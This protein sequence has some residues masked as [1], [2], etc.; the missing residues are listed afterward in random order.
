ML[1]GKTIPVWLVGLMSAWMVAA[2]GEAQETSAREPVEEDWG[3]HRPVVS[4]DGRTIAFMSNRS[5][6]WSI[7]IMPLDGSTGPHRVSDDPR[8]EWYGDWSPDGSRLTYY[9]SDQDRSFLRSYIVATGEEHPMGPQ[10]GN[11]GGPRWTPDGE[12][13]LYTCR[14]LG[15]CAMTPEG[16]DRGVAYGLDGGQHDP[17]L[18]PDGEWIAFVD[19]LV[20]DAQD[21]FIVRVDGSARIRVTEDPGRTYGVDWSPD[22]RYLAYNTEVDGNADIYL[23]DLETGSSRR[24]TT[25]AAEEHLPRWAP[26]GSYLV[27]TSDRTGAERIY[28]MSP[29]GGDLRMIVTEVAGS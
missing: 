24:L 6:T 16:D 20:D 11:R 4:P 7:Y 1:K 19:P 14:G 21:A 29:D 26:D 8:G 10:D 12:T 25:D 5:G 28:R 2:C 13:L 3:D 15:V 18:S 27:F 17:A 22:G 23:Y 9:R